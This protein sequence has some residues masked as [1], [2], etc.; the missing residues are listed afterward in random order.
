MKVIKI[1]YDTRRPCTVEEVSEPQS[2]CCLKD[3]KALINIDCAEIVLTNLR[4]SSNIVLREYVLIVDE[5]GKCK[6]GWEDRINL[7]ASQF[8]EGTLFGDPIVGDVVLSAREWLWFGSEYDLSG[9]LDVEINRIMEYLK[10]EVYF[11]C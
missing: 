1:P 5:V 8:Y 7:R 11:K 6:D 10:S 3:I 9:L 4:K 2:S